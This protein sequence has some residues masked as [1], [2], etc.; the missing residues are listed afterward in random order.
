MVGA[1]GAGQVAFMEL[2]HWRA[3][4]A[5]KRLKV[6]MST[7]KPRLHQ[8]ERHRAYLHRSGA[9][10]SRD[11]RGYARLLPPKR[12]EAASGAR[13]AAQQNVRTVMTE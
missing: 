9:S 8:P 4:P 11:R 5:P 1:A 6:S 12:V 7:R 3:V 10:P 13:S 2:R